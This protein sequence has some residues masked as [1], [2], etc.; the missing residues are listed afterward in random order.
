MG[1]DNT[2]ATELRGSADEYGEAQTDQEA[3]PVSDATRYR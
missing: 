1:Y 2:H 3:P